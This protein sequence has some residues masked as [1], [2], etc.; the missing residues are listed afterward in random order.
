[1]NIKDIIDYYKFR[2]NC[3]HMQRYFLGGI[4]QYK[5]LLKNN[6]CTMN[7]CIKFEGEEKDG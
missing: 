7:N 6:R 3:T 4:L 1:M 5:C 2:C